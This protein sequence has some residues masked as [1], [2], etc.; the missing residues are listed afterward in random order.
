MSAQV[1]KIIERATKD[2]TKVMRIGTAR[3]HGGGSYSVF[4]KVKFH[5]GNL[6]ITGVEGPTRSGNCYGAC[7]Q[8]D[9]HEWKI[10]NYAAGWSSALERKLRTVWSEWHLNHMKA[11]SKAQEDW[12]KA[13]PVKAVY[14]ESHY[15]KASKA[16]AEAG[17][18]PDADGY[19]YGSAWKHQEVPAEVV[20]FIE[21]LP[22]ADRQPA[23]V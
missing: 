23:W 4:V 19:K 22:D 21:S 18:N 5:D 8:I 11:G 20:E 14:P 12:L 2:L 16:L 6:S 3:T 7:G 13:N 1:N 10:A 9:M 17:L 15:E